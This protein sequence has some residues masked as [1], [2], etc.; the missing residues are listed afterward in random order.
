VQNRGKL[1]VVD[2]DDPA[3]LDQAAEVEQVDEHEVEAVV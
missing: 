2:E 1:I 3:G